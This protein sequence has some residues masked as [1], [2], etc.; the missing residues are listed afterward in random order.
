MH[1]TDLAKA[2]GAVTSKFP[3]L[4]AN[5]R[6]PLCLKQRSKLQH[7]ARQFLMVNRVRRRRYIALSDARSGAGSPN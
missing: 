6:A 3:S 7:P 1:R 4:R 5:Q 2:S